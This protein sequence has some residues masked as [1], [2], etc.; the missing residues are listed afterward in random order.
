MSHCHLYM[1]TCA[2]TLC[3]YLAITMCYKWLVLWTNRLN[4]EVALLC[5]VCL[6]VMNGFLFIMCGHVDGK[7]SLS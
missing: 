4:E 6:S 7:V 3:V 5:F 2:D 1:H